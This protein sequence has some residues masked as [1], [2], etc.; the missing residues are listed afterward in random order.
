MTPRKG[1]G[2]SM[3]SMAMKVMNQPVPLVHV[4]QNTIAQKLHSNQAAAVAVKLY[5]TFAGIVVGIPAGLCTYSTRLRNRVGTA[6]VVGPVRRARGASLRERMGGRLGASAVCGPWPPPPPRRD[7]PEPG[8]CA[9]CPAANRCKVRAQ[10]AHGKLALPTRKTTR[11]R[12]RNLGPTEA[13]QKA[14][15]LPCYERIALH[16]VHT[17]T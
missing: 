4:S 11:R 8:A 9:P 17:K 10:G 3:K 2:A 5:V 15:M 14:C 12:W 1:H 13:V 7:G 16:T 6:V